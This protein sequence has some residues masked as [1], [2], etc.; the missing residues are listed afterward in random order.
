MNE[1]EELKRKTFEKI[2]E[3]QI[4]IDSLIFRSNHL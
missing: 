4:D 3:D 1:W 2:N